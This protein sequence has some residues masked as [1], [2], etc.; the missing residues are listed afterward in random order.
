MIG[1]NNIF[2]KVIRKI[3][4]LTQKVLKVDRIKNLNKM[5]S[6][7]TTYFDIIDIFAK[8]VSGCESE[9]V[10]VFSRILYAD[11]LFIRYMYVN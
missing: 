4:L 7:G 1:R 9:I 6:V 10:K 3:M 5:W 11:E 8:Y 2:G